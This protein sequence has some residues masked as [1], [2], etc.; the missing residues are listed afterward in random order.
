[1]CRRV[2]VLNGVWKETMLDCALQTIVLLDE[3]LFA[4]ESIKALL[5][6]KSHTDRRKGVKEKD[7]LHRACH[8]RTR[9]LSYE[10]SETIL[11]DH[12]YGL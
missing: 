9:C 10:N 4:Y 5:A 12:F 1:M 8:P 6:S 11:D 3:S 7:V 2:P